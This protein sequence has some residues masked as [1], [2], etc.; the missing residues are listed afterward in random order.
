MA[1]MVKDLVCDMDVDPDSAAAQSDYQGTTYYFCAVGCKTDFDADPQKYVGDGEASD[2]GQPAEA[3]A[4][5]AI[6]GQ[7]AK[8][9]WQ[10]WK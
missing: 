5:A 4:A 1:E 7:P 3:P 2:A 10:F 8:S 6:E 9:W